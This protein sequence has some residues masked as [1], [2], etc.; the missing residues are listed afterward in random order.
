[1]EFVQNGGQ[2]FGAAVAGEQIVQSGGVAT[3]DLIGGGLVDVQAGG[4]AFVTFTSFGGILELDASQTFS[5]TIGGF[6]SP[7]GVNE[8]IDLRDIAFT[9]ATAVNFTE[10][11]NNNSGTLTV[12][13]GTHIAN[14]TLLGQYT[15]ANF[16]LSSDGNGGTVI[17]DPVGSAASPVL[18]AH[19]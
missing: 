2:A 3:N 16:S 7:A 19:G 13:D 18:A 4:L 8:A 9:S 10:A 14:L 15:A 11:A 5:G 1:V 17:K 12:T 6:A